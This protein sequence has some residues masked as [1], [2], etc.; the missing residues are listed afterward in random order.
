VGLEG[1]NGLLGSI[2]TMYVQRDKLV[3]DLPLVH[4][5]GLEFGADFIAKDSEINIV[6]TVGKVV[7]DGCR[8]PVSVYQTC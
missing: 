2:V 5:G 6:P 7:H 1:L 8:R 3:P 4:Y